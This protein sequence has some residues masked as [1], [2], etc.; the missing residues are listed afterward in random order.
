MLFLVPAIAPELVY[1]RSCYPTRVMVHIKE[2]L[3]LIGKNNLCCGS[4]GFP[5]SHNIK[6]IY[7]ECNVTSQQTQEFS[8]KG[9]YIKTLLFYP[10]KTNEKNIPD[11][12]GLLNKNNSVC[13][14]L[15]E[16]KQRLVLEFIDYFVTIFRLRMC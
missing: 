8:N 3:L 15:T 2:P 5:L 14:H 16:G 9:Q 13:I 7:L 11:S 1:Q 10:K 4:S 6:V 12:K